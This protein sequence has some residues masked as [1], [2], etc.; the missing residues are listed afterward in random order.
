LFAAVANAPWGCPLR[1]TPQQV[2]EFQDQGFLTLPNVV[3]LG[4][5]SEVRALL[6]PLFERFDSL[7][8]ASVRDI[9]AGR[10]EKRIAEARSPEVNRAVRLEPRLARTRVFAACN[11]IA[12]QL[13]GSRASYTF[14]HAI[15]KQPFNER[16]TPWHQDQAYTGHRTSLKTVHFWI[17]L[18]D[19]DERSGCMQFIPGSHRRGLL[20]HHHRDHDPTAHALMTDAVD[21]RE[22]IA[23]PIPAGGMTLHTP[24]TLH[25]TRP[26]ATDQV[27]RAWII[28]FGPYGRLGKLRPSILAEKLMAMV[29][30][31][32]G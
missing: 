21:S 7:P 8:R 10:D 13:C 26:N 15:Y 11:E 30:R 29:R 22:A 3:D 17:P 24:F 4:A 5:V 20:P 1:L 32:L 19:V 27:R 31:R 2:A 25:Y 9:S 23:C 18:Q 14:D 12:R 28:H 16:E 6:D